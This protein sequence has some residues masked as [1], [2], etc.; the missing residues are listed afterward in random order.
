M[1][2]KSFGRNLSFSDLE[3]ANSIKHNRS[4]STLEAIH[5]AINWKSIS[6]IL[7]SD[8]KPGSKKDGAEAYPPIL[9]FKCMLLQ[10]WFR[11]PSGPELETQIN[12]RI[13]F[14]RFLQLPLG[15]QS[16][17]YSTFSRFRA[18][19]SKD[20]MDKINTEILMQFDVQGLSINEGIA[21]E[22]SCLVT[23]VS[24]AILLPEGGKE[25]FTPRKKPLVSHKIGR[26]CPCI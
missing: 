21:N 22:G 20:V 18:R 4:V 24:C 25:G 19:L 26:L 16:P 3:M 7:L 23:Q 5:N 9:L 13:S 8:Y 15:K 12:D 2:F 11:S 6:D 14:K 1:G 10:K 17:D